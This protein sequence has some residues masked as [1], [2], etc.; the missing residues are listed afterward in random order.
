M[1]TRSETGSKASSVST[2]P[3]VEVLRPSFQRS[4][5]AQNKSPK[6]V[7]TYLEALRPFQ[8]FVVELGMPQ[9]VT[10]LRRDHVE[11]FIADSF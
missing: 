10:S 9:A 1:A 8:A 6:T 2:S 3:T 4:L 5:P 7:K 11:S